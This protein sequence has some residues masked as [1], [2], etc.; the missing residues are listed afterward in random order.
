MA[1]IDVP[2][3]TVGEIFRLGIQAAV[4]CCLTC[5]FA[6]PGLGAPPLSPQI[7]QLSI[8]STEADWKATPHFSYIERDAD[9]KGR[10]TTSKTYR[11]CMIDGSPYSRM[12]AIDDK[13][14]SPAQDARQNEKLRKEIDKRA[15]ESSTQRRKRLVDYQKD[16]ERMLV[17]VQQMADAFDFRLLGGRR[18]DD[19][20]VDVFEALPRPEYRPK[21][22]EAKMLTGMKGMLWID[23]HT[24]QW[25]RVDAEAFKPV[26]MGWFVAEV[27]PGTR[28]L[29]EQKPV[30]ENLW[31]PAHLNVEVKARILGLKKA[32]RHDE[33]YRDYRALPGFAIPLASISP[34][35]P[36]GAPCASYP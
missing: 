12:I 5:A 29:L 27:S 2:G 25:V 7:V 20:D 15:N 28:F 13:P 18:I 21:N 36:G 16:R 19:R 9:V 34:A 22:R 8:A 33:T 24:Y 10:V 32:Y 11:V 6:I 26:R 3:E 4:A 17:L 1:G 30:G 14:L 23:K 31:L 35:A